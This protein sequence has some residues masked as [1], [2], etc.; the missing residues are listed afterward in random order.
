MAKFQ[1]KFCI[2]LCCALTSMYSDAQR[3]Y[4]IQRKNLTWVDARNY[5]QACFKELVTLTPDNSQALARNITYDH[6]IGLRK[7]FNFKNNS[8]DN[9]TGDLTSTVASYTETSFTTHYINDSDS[10]S[11]IM[12][13]TQWA[14]GDPLAFQN[15][16]PG[17]PL[18]KPSPKPPNKTVCCS[19]SCTCPAR[20]TTPMTTN[21]EFTTPNTTTTQSG[22]NVTSWSH[23]PAETTEF[24]PDFT[25]TDESTTHVTGTKNMTTQRT[26]P[27]FST[28]APWT[29]PE[30]P[31][32]AQCEKSPVP[33]PQ[34]PEDEDDSN[35]KNYI[36]DSC[37][38]MLSF[39]P[40][41]E[42]SCLE[43]LPFIC[44]EDRFMGQVNVTNITFESA[45]LTW[46]VAPGDI[47][48]YRV[49]VKGQKD[50]KTWVFNH[51]GLTYGL[52]N[53][54]A[55]TSYSV[56]VFP[57]KCERDLNPENA[58]FYT[59]PKAVTNLTVSSVEKNSVR[60]SWEK[61]EGNVDFYRLT[62]ETNTVKVTTETETVKDLIPGTPYNFTVVSGVNDASKWSYEA[63]VSACTKPD[64]VYN[65]TVSNNTDQ[66]M[67]VR[68]DRPVGNFT[69]IRVVAKNS[70]G[71]SLFNATVNHTQQHETVT[72]LPPATHIFISV[73]VRVN[74]GLVGETVNIDSFTTPGPI[75]NLILNTTNDS[76]TATWLPPNGSALN[77]TVELSL[78]QTLVN[79]KNV[80]DTN[81]TFRGLK[82]AANYSV[83]IYA[84]S[85]Q[86]K[87]TAESTYKF[88]LPNPPGPP[89]ASSISKDSITFA[90]DAPGNTATPTYGVKLSSSFWG[91]SWSNT[92]SDTTFTFLNLTS[93]TNYSFSVYTIA[94]G[95]KSASVG[96]ANFTVPDLQEISL[97]MLCSSSEPLLCDNNTTRT[98]VFNQLNNTFKNLLDGHIDWH[99]E[100]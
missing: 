98:A 38:A 80:S 69:D 90:W 4:F 37:V 73:T 79:T 62:Y 6:W 43:L 65:L 60:L 24:T 29:T 2:L 30:M 17:W 9:S 89:T 67:V 40:W 58:T 22:H 92:T 61:P 44:Y 33:E 55:G 3:E 20:P 52:S 39:G 42:K 18:P 82:N 16:Y 97:S 31:L 68:W 85:G 10:S 64:K 87:S 49:E 100:H 75:S 76:L 46:M 51:T 1:V 70:S 14:N 13:W 23:D 93:G 34:E 53:L 41:I 35:D 83:A 8:I 47:S 27:Y 11:P 26:T 91:Q 5:C 19:C 57:V 94:D 21:A 74:E 25:S 50:N 32:A 95:Q 99:L 77:F 7:N 66:S 88:T 12:N 96:C 59:I 45:N 78:D 28:S 71:T 86:F 84:V 48:H 36:E 63:H 15:W 72:G 56:Q 81:I 54:T